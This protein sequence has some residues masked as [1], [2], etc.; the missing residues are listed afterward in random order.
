MRSIRH[1]LVSVAVASLALVG[2]ASP[3]VKEC[4]HED[5]TACFWDA[6]T[7]GNGVGRSFYADQAGNITYIEGR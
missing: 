6:S 3:S 7:H 2:C 1:A 5:S 4:A